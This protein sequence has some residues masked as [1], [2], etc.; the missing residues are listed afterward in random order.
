MSDSKADAMND[1]QQLLGGLVSSPT[2]TETPAAETETT[3]Q[4]GF[5]EFGALQEL[6]VKPEILTMRDHL[7]RIEGELPEIKQV[8]A[9]VTEL[10]QALPQIRR[11][12]GRLEHLEAVLPEWDVV[13][14]KVDYLEDLVPTVQQQL[15]DIEQNHTPAA[16]AQTLLP[17]IIERLDQRL[18][19]HVAQLDG[20]RQEQFQKAIAQALLPLMS[21][22]LDQQLRQQLE[23]HFAQL[24]IRL[25]ARLEDAIAALPQ[26]SMPPEELSFR[27]WAIDP[28]TP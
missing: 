19:Q 18:A 23:L 16:I 13:K 10:S 7:A 21:E 4:E 15:Q 24:E 26:G 2:P 12:Q 9:Q 1:L 3:D 25:Q 5:D 11:M 27:V 14:R 20:Q 28:D 17:L 8:K 22:H 6:L